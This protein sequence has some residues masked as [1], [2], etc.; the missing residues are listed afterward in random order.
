M[1]DWQEYIRTNG[2]ACPHC[3]SKHIT[4]QNVNGN[5]LSA[6]IECIK[7]KEQWQAFFT[8]T[9]VR[10]DGKDYTL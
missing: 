1:P 3:G 2:A 8:L 4:F 10:C 7:C 5:D 6:D 9:E